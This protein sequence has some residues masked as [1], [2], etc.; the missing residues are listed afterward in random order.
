M[1][2]LDATDEAPTSMTSPEDAARQIVDA[3]EHGRF[4]VVSGRDA[5]LLDRLSRLMPRRTIDLVAKKMAARLERAWKD[6]LRRA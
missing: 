3:V 5:R 6:F 4:R 1:P 2:D